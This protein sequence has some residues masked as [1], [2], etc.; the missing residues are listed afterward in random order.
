MERPG[1]PAGHEEEAMKSKTKVSP[2]VQKWERQIPCNRCAIQRCRG[3]CA[4]Y[5]KWYAGR[6]KEYEP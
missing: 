1:E 5:E 2:I 4:K 6:P 3:P